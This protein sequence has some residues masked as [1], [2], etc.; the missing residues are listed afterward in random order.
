MDVTDANPDPDCLVSCVLTGFSDQVAARTSATSTRYQIIRNRRGTLDKSSVVKRAPLIVASGISEIGARGQDVEVR[1]SQA[2]AIDQERLLSIFPK[3]CT[4]TLS[5]EY[6]PTA[7]HVRGY[8]EVWFRDVCISRERGPEPDLE[9]AAQVLARHVLAG[10]L[11]IKGW[12]YRVQVWFARVNLIAHQC[13]DLGIPEVDT[14][15]QQDMLTHICYGET[16]AK[17]IRHK[18]VWPAVYGWLSKEQKAAVIGL[19]PERI[20]LTNGRSPK[21]IYS[22]TEPPHVC[23]RVQE[24]Y[25]V[26]SIPPIAMGNVTPLVHVLAPN[27]R[28]VQITD[29]LEGFWETSYPQIKKDLKGRYPKHEWR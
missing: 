11:S 26:T 21:V 19:A 8:N 27:Q 25:D 9:K 28:L 2:S 12:D 3:E 17:A 14:Q 22:S 23:L 10:D 16:G 7:K 4:E 24:L 18:D 13:P 20:T 6:D 5:V 15:A 1:I 29:N